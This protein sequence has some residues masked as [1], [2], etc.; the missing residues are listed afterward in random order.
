MLRIGIED[1]AIATG[2][3]FLPLSELADHNGIDV[4]KYYVGLGQEQFSWVAEDEDIVTMAAS[5]AQPILAPEVKT[6][7]GSVL[8]ATETGIDQSKSAGVYLQSLLDL[9]KNIRVIEVKQ[10]CYAAAAALQLACAMVAREPNKK[11]LVIGSDVAKYE[12]GGTGEPTQGAAAVALL[13]SASPKLIE[14]DATT[15]VFT[16]DTMDFWRPNYSTTAHVDGKTSI[17]AYLDAVKGVWQDYQAKGGAPYSDFA[18]FCY[19]QPFTKMA[20]KAHRTLALENGIRLT[21]P[22]V[23]EQIASTTVYNRRLGNSYT[24]SLF[25]ALLS[26]LENDNQDLSGKRIGLLSFGS[27]SVA[28]FFSGIVCPGYQGHLRGKDHQQMLADRVQLTYE[29]YAE[30]H[31]RSLPTDGSRFQNPIVSTGAFRFAGLADHKRLYEAR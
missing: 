8:F 18:R 5:A 27:G 13:V 21:S 7:L 28:E 24:A 17:S 25:S 6:E 30:L 14:F 3:Y 9:P 12:M 4:Q 16:N 15:G 10:A 11:V 31:E 26:L 22:Q 19:H 2:H 1:A 23:E 29:K 20:A